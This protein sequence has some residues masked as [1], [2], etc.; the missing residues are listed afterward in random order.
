MR[1]VEALADGDYEPT[2]GFEK[3]L[4]GVIGGKGSA[5]TKK[6]IAWLRYW[7]SYLETGHATRPEPFAPVAC[8]SETLNASTSVLNANQKNSP[9]K[10]ARARKLR[11]ASIAESRE[12]RSERM[13]EEAEA[14]S[15]WEVAET[16]VS[17]EYDDSPD[18]YDGS[19]YEQ[20]VPTL[21]DGIWDL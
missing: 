18:D 6:E 12:S 20:M 11:Y 2:S 15:V 19:D 5:C 21:D 1:R 9:L 16:D 17:L 14:G 10:K 13:A 8:E 4:V 3:H 7:E